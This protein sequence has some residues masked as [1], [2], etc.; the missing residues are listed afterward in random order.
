MHKK[1]FFIFL[2]LFTSFLLF[3]IDSVNA[4][5][6][7]SIYALEDNCNALLGDPEVDGT[8]ANFLQQI[9]TIMG[10][11]APILCVV[12]SMVDFIKASASQDKDA[13]MKAGKN[14]A[15]RLVLALILFFLPA[16]INFIFPLLGWYGT[17]G[18]K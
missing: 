14:T 6:Y 8:V 17:C 2:I 13:L 11:L 7:D 16:L 1:I 9:F 3:N 4:A 12:L 5:T 18:I 15:K 10:Y